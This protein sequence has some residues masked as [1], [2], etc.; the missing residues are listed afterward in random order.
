MHR[1]V[2]W[3]FCIQTA[4]DFGYSCVVLARGGGVMYVY[5]YY[6]VWLWWRKVRFIP[7]LTISISPSPSLSIVSPL[8][9]LLSLS[10]YIYI[11]SLSP[12][13]SPHPLLSL[14]LSL[15][16]SHSLCLFLIFPKF[17]ITRS[18]LSLS[19]SLSLSSLVSFALSNHCDVYQF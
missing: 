5:W 7:F 18:Y 3:S 6:G 19:L 1:D 4:D 16:L 11:V 17:I 10:I 2:P 15:S 14:S 12:P 8:Y 9:F 13:L